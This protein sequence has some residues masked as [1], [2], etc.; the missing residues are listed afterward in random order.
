MF[1]DLPDDIIDY[2]IDNLF[3]NNHPIELLELRNINKKLRLKIDNKK[4]KSSIINEDTNINKSIN[5]LLRK[6]TNI[7]QIEWLLKNHVKFNLNHNYT[8]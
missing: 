8:I 4:L 2:I 1:H 7:K 5:D 3:D 6:N